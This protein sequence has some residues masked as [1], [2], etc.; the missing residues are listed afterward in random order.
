MT[1]RTTLLG[2]CVVLLMVAAVTVSLAGAQNDA[3]GSKSQAVT[4]I[5]YLPVIGAGGAELGEPAARNDATAFTR[6]ANAALLAELPF[7]DTADFD[8]AQRGFIVPLPDE[9][10][11]TPDGSRIIWDPGLFD[12]VEMGSSAPDTVNPSLWRQSQLTSVSGLFKVTDRIYQVRN[13]DLSN[14]TIIE[15]DTGLIIADPLIS[16]ET[17][18]NALKLYFEHRP[19]APVVAVIYSHS[20]IDHYGG[21]AGITTQAAVDAGTVTIYAPEGFLEAAIKENVYAGNAMTRRAG[22]M[23]GALLPADEK[24]QVGAGL[25]TTVS[26]GTVTLIAPTQSI[27]ADNATLTIDGLTFEFLLAPDTEAPSEMMWYIREL[28]ALTAAEDAVHTM[29]NVYSLRGAKVRDPLAWSK[30]L[31]E[32]LVRWGPET[33][34]LY[35]MHHWPVWDTAV[36]EDFLK[37]QR[38]LY[39]FINDQTLRLANQGYTMLEIAEM[40]ELPE[41]LATVWS[42]RGYY[43]SLNHNVKATYDKYLGWFDGNPANLHPLPPVEASAKYVEFMGGADNVLAMARESY[44]RGEYRWVAQVVNHVVFAEPDNVEARNLQADVLEQ[45]G[46]QAESGPWRNFYLSGAQELRDGVDSSGNTPNSASPDTIRALPLDLFFDYLALHLN[47]PRAAGKTITI[48]WSFTDTGE[49]Y[50]TEMENAVLNH[51]G[52][53][54]SPNPDARITLER[55]TLNAILTGQMTIFHAI[56]TGKVQVEGNRLKVIEQFVLLDRF[57]FWF[58]I[59]TP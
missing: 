53:A 11:V 34:V 14:L 52:D 46:Y 58:D 28:R 44:A 15:G 49:L 37:K 12:F 8:D 55:E 29:H 47:G 35:G 43:G 9:V 30:Y 36:V 51:T 5:S 33:D 32:A 25:G 22:Y 38:D 56:A 3:A 57:E 1:K 19:Q 54:Q 6:A 7:D 23:Y 20:H 59:V 26:K 18:A 31:N 42:S 41:S 48:N 27:T 13:Q 24:G 40:I 39:R 45:L 2:I 10:L 21:V 16:A 50:L 4:M 17:A